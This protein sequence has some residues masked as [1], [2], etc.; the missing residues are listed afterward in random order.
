MERR[1]GEGGKEEGN[2]T[3]ICRRAILSRDLRATYNAHIYKPYPSQ[4][5]HLIHSSQMHS[6]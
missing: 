2:V 6:Q 3:V 1:R 5:V 4:N